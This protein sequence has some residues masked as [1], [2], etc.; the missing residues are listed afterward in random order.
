MPSN[1]YFSF[2]ADTGNDLQA[3]D[4]SGDTATKTGTPLTET[5]GIVEIDVDGNGNYYAVTSGAEVVKWDSSFTEIWRSQIQSASV[6]DLSSG[7]GGISVGNGHVVVTA[8]DF[9]NRGLSILDDLGTVKYEDK[10]VN[11]P[12]SNPVHATQTNDRFY[13]AY[14][15]F[16]GG[17]IIVGKYDYNGNEKTT[18]NTFENLGNSESKDNH[19]QLTH[20]D[21][22]G[23]VVGAGMHGSTEGLLAL[24]VDETMSHVGTF[25]S[26]NSLD[27]QGIYGA[28]SDDN[29]HYI[30]HE[31]GLY[32]FDKNVNKIA[33][34]FSSSIPF[35]DS[36]FLEAT[37]DNL[38]LAGTQ[39]IV[40][41]DKSLNTVWEYNFSNEKAF[42]AEGLIPDYGD[43]PSAWS[44]FGGP[45]VEKLAVTQSNV[46]GSSPSA[47]LSSVN[48]SS[49]QS[50]ST[51]TTIDPIEN[52]N[53]S[54]GQVSSTGVLSDALTSLSLDSVSPQVLSDSGQGNLSQA[55][56]SGSQGSVNSEILI[57]G[58]SSLSS[59]A[60][61]VSSTGEALVT[62]ASF[63]ILID[64][65][66]ESGKVSSSSAILSGFTLSSTR[67]DVGSQIFD[68]GVGLS[69]DSKQYVTQVDTV[70]TEQSRLS[71]DSKQY[72]TQV[73]TV[74]TEQSRLSLDITQPSPT[75]DTRSAD[76]LFTAFVTAV[77]P[78]IQGGRLNSQDSLSLNSSPIPVQ[79]TLPELDLLLLEQ[80]DS[81]PVVVESTDADTLLRVYLNSNQVQ[82]TGT[83]FDSDLDKMNISS[84]QSDVTSTPLSFILLDVDNISVTSSTNTGKIINFIIGGYENSI[85]ITESKNNTRIYRGG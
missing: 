61:R 79:F 72:V 18:I 84:I 66:Q 7:R 16:S 39:N 49:N 1:A 55:T 28:T 65:I 5:N 71:L 3:Y 68:V 57:S 50:Q 4:I 21:T 40:K 35:F 43:F 60:T 62:E 51:A 75:I 9:G 83:K 67:E 59:S 2:N 8:L 10:F 24:A 26:T 44:S 36:D 38:I 80:I 32:K 63:N 6:P 15:D 74:F 12:P 52:I 78:L 31:S 73:D 20:R 47:R 70:F 64:A 19:I 76:L 13:L 33:R 29:A 48:T 81:L 85:S 77:Q 45:S 46:V 11:I 27:F 41:F 53:L 56:L 14:Q 58:V 23:V 22:G 82:S 30:A 69:L 37:P 34:T 42:E 25:K 17:Y 54:I